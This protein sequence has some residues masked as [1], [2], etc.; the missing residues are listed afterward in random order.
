MKSTRLLNALVLPLFVCALALLT[1]GLPALSNSSPRISAYLLWQDK[2]MPLRRAGIIRQEIKSKPFFFLQ[3]DGLSRAHC[4]RLVVQASW[5]KK[6]KSL[7]CKGKKLGY[8]IAMSTLPLGKQ[9]FS[10]QVGSQTWKQDFRFCIDNYRSS[11]EEVKTPTP[12]RTSTIV[13]PNFIP[14]DPPLLTSTPTIAIPTGPQPTN[15]PTRT[16]TNTPTAIATIT[17]TPTLPLQLG[18]FDLTFCPGQ[19]YNCGSL[20]GFPAGWWT[21]NSVWSPGNNIIEYTQTRSRAIGRLINNG[22]ISPNGQII[23]PS[24]F[25]MVDFEP[26]FDWDM[27]ASFI[28][29]RIAWIREEAPNAR[30]TLYGYELPLSRFN[31][32]LIISNPSWVQAAIDVEC[33]KWQPVVQLMDSVTLSFYLIGGALER[34]LAYIPAAVAQA[35]RCFP[36]TPISA[37][38][39]GSYHTEVSP[40]AGLVSVQDL[41]RYVS[42]VKA[43]VDGIQVWGLRSDNELLG[44][45]LR[46]PG[47]LD[48]PPGR[49]ST[50][51]TVDP[52]N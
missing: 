49:L 24:L 7:R 8:E 23:T 51:L 26:A 9:C 16:V 22:G 38:L 30:L 47:A 15:T 6:S 45:V 46:E 52:N 25:T 13:P 3:L 36:N 19:T 39:W 28:Q 17:P 35:R 44:Q 31:R 5:R 20:S 27:D 33:Q 18:V 14:A 10:V 34:D 2:K 48:L 40:G 37:L 11:V 29:Q 12:V 43:L 50:W 4:T 21:S 41:R 32:D 1:T 42:I